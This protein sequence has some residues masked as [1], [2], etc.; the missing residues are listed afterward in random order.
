MT[1]PAPLDPMAT[2]NDI[3][4]LQEIKQAL[5]QLINTGDEHLI[6]IHTLPLSPAEHQNLLQWLGDGEVHAHLTALGGSDIRETAIAGVWLTTHRNAEG[7]I[8]T[9][10]IEIT[11]IPGILQS[12]TDDMKAGLLQ[13]Q[14]QLESINPP[15]LPGVN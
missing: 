4:L 12:Q 8:A 15:S 14:Q 11:R 13:L 7:E 6:N 1:T 3:L 5:V 2:G 10:F 9:Q